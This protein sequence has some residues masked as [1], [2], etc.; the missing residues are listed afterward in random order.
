LYNYHEE[1]LDENN[2]KIF[3][4]FKKGEIDKKTAEKYIKEED[5][6]YKENRS[7][8]SRFLKKSIEIAE[9]FKIS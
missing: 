4:K 8:Y 6:K 2:E 3:K 1:I 7:N 5:S 9:K